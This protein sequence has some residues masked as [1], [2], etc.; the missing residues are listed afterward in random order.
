[1]NY[2][3]PDRDGRNAVDFYHAV[4]ENNQPL[5]CAFEEFL[6]GGGENIK[7]RIR[8]LLFGIV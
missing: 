8:A 5:E 2:D 6:L 4:K 1:M 7:K 3:M